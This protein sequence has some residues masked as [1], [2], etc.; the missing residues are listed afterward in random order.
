MNFQVKGKLTA[1]DNLPPIEELRAIVLQRHP[2][3]A[4]SQSRIR[5]AQ[6]QL[7]LERDLRYP[8]PKIMAGFERDPDLDQWRIG[9]SIHLSLWYQRQGPIA[10]AFAELK[11]REAAADQHHLVLLHEI[12]AAYT[13]YHVADRQEDAFESGLLK[14]A[15]YALKVAE[16]AYR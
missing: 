11:Q 7:Q 4:L 2:T 5:Q 9:F 3:V 8:Q 12:G 13:R 16:T 1:P 6:G 14:E 10:E 15:Q